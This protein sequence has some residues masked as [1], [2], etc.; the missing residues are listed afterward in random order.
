MS[1]VKK[2]LTALSLSIILATSAIYAENNNIGVEQN[3]QVDGKKLLQDAYNYLGNLNKY[4][5]NAKI[6]NYYVADSKEL[7][8][9][10][11]SVVHVNRPSQFKIN[12]KDEY[13]DRTVYLNDGV[14]T[15]MDNKEKY[16]AT[17]NT[18]TNI[19]QTLVKIRKNLGIV[20]PLSTFMHSDMNKFIKPNKVQYFGTRDLNGVECNYIAFRLG[21]TVIHMWIENSNR[22]LIRS[23]KIITKDK[24]TTDMVLNWDVEDNFKNDIFIFKAPKNASNISIRAAK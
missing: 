2:V 10:R 9:K 11:N 24:G 6:T 17:V 23:A 13:I 8:E 18:G 1:Y 12:T 14:F 16:Y 20:L 3:S 5:L 7:V 21:K 15:M 22:P 19:D 4:T